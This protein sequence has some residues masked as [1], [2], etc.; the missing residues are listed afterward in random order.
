VDVD[1]FAAIERSWSGGGGNAKLDRARKT[2]A[3]R[4]ERVVGATA[5]YMEAMMRRALLVLMAL[6]VGAGC[7][8]SQGP[9]GPEGPAGNNGATGTMG[10]MGVQGEQGPPGTNGATGATG[11]AGAQGPVGPQGPAGI[12]QLPHLIVAATGEDLGPMTNDGCSF[13]PALKAETCYT[14]SFYFEQQ[15]CAGNRY[16]YAWAHANAKYVTETGAVFSTGMAVPAQIGS[17]SYLT[18][19][20]TT[21]WGTCTNGGGSQPMK[22][23]T[24]TGE[25]AVF[26]GQWELAVEIR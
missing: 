2:S 17:A 13:N 16:V 12:A 24:A 21:G 9:S 20:P 1:D 3:S 23:L 22:L 11:P 8:G 4:R 5:R 25:Q 18:Q 15:A 14:S 7:N 26:H 10:T 6:G 19:Q